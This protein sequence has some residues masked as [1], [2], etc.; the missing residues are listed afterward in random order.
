MV[1]VPENVDAI[2]S[3]IVADWRISARKIAETLEI[4]SGTCRIHH[5]LD[6]RNLSSKWVPKCLSV[7]QKRDHVVAPKSILEH[8]RWNMVGFLAL[9][10]TM[11]KTWIHLYDPETKE[12]SKHSWHSDSSCPQK[13]QTQK[14]ASKVMVSVF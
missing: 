3:M 5:V 11:D 4:D 13:F 10:V 1:T 9:L 7:D 6:K 8:F 12:Q 14:S 2:H